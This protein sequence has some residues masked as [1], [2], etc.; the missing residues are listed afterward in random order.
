MDIKKKVL[1]IISLVILGIIVYSPH[2]VYHLPYHLDEWDH[3]GRSIRMQEQGISY[4]SNSSPVEIGFD[5]IIIIFSLILS[6]IKVDIVNFYQFLPA[7]NATIVGLILFFCLRKEFKQ[8]WIGLCALPFLAFMPSNVNILG[9]WF[10]V[11]IIAAIPFIY[12]SLFNLER[13]IRDNEPKRLYLVA[14]FLF[15]VAFIH[16]SSF[17]VI[18]LSVLICMIFNHKFVL[19]NRKY[20][21]P[22]LILIIPI[23]IMVYYLSSGFTDLPRFFS[24]FIW[25]PITP[26]INYNPFTFYG[27]LASFFALFGFYRCIKEKKLLSLRIYAVISLISILAFP[28]FEKTIFSA[29]QRYIYHFMI[30][31][32][33]LSA[34]GFYY[35]IV[36]IKN[37]LKV[38]ENKKT[39]VLT[40]ITLILI[41]G[42]SFNYFTLHPQA[43]LYHVIEPGEIEGL[44]LL[45]SYPEGNVLVPINM[46]IAVRPITKTH[47]EALNYFAWRRSDNLDMFNSA[48][49]KRKEE[50]LYNSNLWSIPGDYNPG[51]R[52]EKNS[53]QYLFSKDEINCDFVEKIYEKDYYVYKLNLDKNILV[54]MQDTYS[55]SKGYSATSPKFLVYNFTLN[56]TFYPTDL[57]L[58]KSQIIR[59]DYEGDGY[60]TGWS[61]IIINKK[62]ILRAGNVTST[63]ELTSKDSLI[64]GK[65]NEVIISYNGN[66]K[67]TLNGK[68]QFDSPVEFVYNSTEKN[69]IVMGK[70]RDYATPGDKFSLI[71]INNENKQ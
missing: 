31:C 43:K 68:Q 34:I 40:I 14:L 49:C 63:T 36:W 29:Y 53:I 65:N 48:D 24:H 1:L 62:V 50:Y 9:I 70:Q 11:P 6:I 52:K 67:M 7:I 60:H 15:I 45:S 42:M 21:Y 26:Q 4:F 39:I 41:V 23:L 71:L 19:H 3:I 35:S 12:L 54:K 58:S 61:A 25:G 57:G 30:A 51:G 47:D 37:K 5:F 32:V 69:R 66:F 64:K 17:L 2:F 16:Q 27:I 46:G 22:L 8:Y 38:K 59:M 55:Y 13:S 44:K 20:F 56:S 28:L 33:P 18:A 10:Y